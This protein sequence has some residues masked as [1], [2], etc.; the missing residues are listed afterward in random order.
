MVSASPIF[1]RFGLVAAILL[2][3]LLV[4]F[5]LSWMEPPRSAPTL[6]V[7]WT[8]GTKDAP[9]SEFRYV[10]FPTRGGIPIYDK[11]NGSTVGTLRRAVT[12]GLDELDMRF[13]PVRDGSVAGVVEQAALRRSVSASEAKALIGE[14]VQERRARPD[15]CSDFALI[16]EVPEHG[17]ESSVHMVCGGIFS[18]STYIVEG[19]T[20][21][22][23]MFALDTKTG[24][25]AKQ[26]IPIPWWF[27]YSVCS[28][29]LIVAGGL[30]TLLRRQPAL[31]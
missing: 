6:P 4:A 10:L 3:W 25:A 1:R 18:K 5:A 30:W 20:I 24:I 22:P 8:A 29:P 2:V 27:A 28:A 21:R 19:E 11:P 12:G 16:A 17:G 15:G 23:V 7:R 26:P 31:R 14:L 9:P 13:V